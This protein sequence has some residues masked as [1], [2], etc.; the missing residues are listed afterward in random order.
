MD[1]VIIVG[2]GECYYKLVGKPLEEMQR[3][4][5]V[6]VIGTV[7]LRPKDAS[8]QDPFA[9]APHIL[10]EKKQSLCEV[11]N[12]YK[13][14]NPVVFLI[15]SNEFHTP[16]AEEL[17]E[18]GFRALVEKPY[19]ITV[20][21][22]NIMKNLVKN[23]PKSIALAEYY[24]AMKSAALMVLAGIVKKDGFLFTD[25]M[26]KPQGNLKD[27]SMLH[28]KLRE[29]IGEPKKVS[30]YI[31]EGILDG[32]GSVDYRGPHLTDLRLGGGMI[33]DLGLHALTPVLALEEYLGSINPSFANGKIK[34]A[35]A[36]E[37]IAMAEQKFGLML[38]DI[39]ESYAEMDLVTSQ[40]I[41]VHIAV[42]KY[43][44]KNNRQ[45]IIE[46]SK[47]KVVLDLNDC[48]LTCLPDNNAS[49]YFGC[50]LG[51]QKSYVPVI[52][53]GLEELSSKSAYT[54]SV[55]AVAWNAQEL[56]LN[57]LNKAHSAKQDIRYASTID[58]PEKIFK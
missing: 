25:N 20:P 47:G 46:G 44:P 48:V 29:V 14:K 55:T 54:I 6:N 53:S 51:C 35:R 19:S 23:H 52:R 30:V 57:V 26:L 13:E 24:L 18:G 22:A 8:K 7:D 10:R 45:I 41:P 38:D 40:G 2:T 1:D 28:G 43:I 21:Q 58:N 39:G 36:H 15:H 42:G 33:Q 50:Q 34:I 3:K 27:P 16:D 31:L 17:I 37:Y 12:N 32:I 4:G 56:V 49:P 11:L 9:N 5:L